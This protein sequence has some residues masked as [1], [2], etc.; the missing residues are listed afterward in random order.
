MFPYNACHTDNTNTQACMHTL[1]Y[2]HVPSS[3][4][5]TTFPSVL[6]KVVAAQ[7][8]EASWESVALKS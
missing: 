2:I 7:D 1:M 5:S 6:E 8:D 4:S 3:N